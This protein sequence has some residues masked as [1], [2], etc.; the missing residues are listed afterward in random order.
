MASDTER[1]R[2]TESRLPARLP[3]Y[4]EL[5]AFEK[6][7]D[8]YNWGVFGDGDQLGTLNF[9]TSERVKRAA[10]L[11]RTG[12]VVNLNLPLDQ[13]TPS[14]LGGS[15][16]PYEHHISV[17][18]GGR[19]DSVDHFFLQYSSQWDSLRHVRY[20][21]YGYYGGL[22][23][24]AVDEGRLGIENM[25]EHG[26]IGRGVLIDLPAYCRKAGLAYSPNDR[27]C[28]D[29]AMIEAIAASQGVALEPGDI[30]VLRTGWVGWFMELDE[31]Q[32]QALQGTVQ[33]SSVPGA[34]ACPGLDPA[35]ETAGWL[36]D[37]QIAAVAAD[38]LAVEAL[39]VDAA[40][41]FQHRR[42]IPLLGM[43]LGELWSL[44]A[45]AAACAADGVYEF[46]LSAAPLNLP[47]GV[48]SPANAYAI[49]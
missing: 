27:I 43:P 10:A 32:R 48:G 35:R 49:R 11:V 41:G 19:D 36:W 17:G 38:N 2:R 25:A 22:E 42:L 3:R 47:G 4:G 14:P 8:H 29:G 23:D 7:G 31:Q 40:V 15:R 24:A 5:P 45:L 20:R 1:Q 26:I 21:E 33:P 46:M 37:H 13:P 30:L 28:M 9:L 39:P 44:E 16:R 12:Q 6:T 18:R 34:L